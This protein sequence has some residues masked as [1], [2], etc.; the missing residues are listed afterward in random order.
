MADHP[1]VIPVSQFGDPSSTQDGLNCTSTSYV[2][3]GQLATGGRFLLPGEF[4]AL[5]SDHEGGISIPDG[6]RAWAKAYPGARLDWA[7]PNDGTPTPPNG[8]GSNIG[9]EAL[10]SL[11]SEGYGAVLQGDYD[12]F[13]KAGISLQPG[14]LDPHAIYLDGVRTI[15]RQRQGFI[16]DPLGRE[17]YN[18]RWVSWATLV[19][20]GLK[21]S[22]GH[23]LYAAWAAQGLPDTGTEDEVANVVTIERK[24]GRVS[25]PPGSAMAG[26]GLAADGTLF[27]SIP[28]KAWPNG[29][30]FRVTS[31]YT[32]TAFP[33]NNGDPITYG[34]AECPSAYCNGPSQSLVPLRGLT[35]IPD[36]LGTTEAYNAG[37]DAASAKALEARK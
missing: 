7:A 8:H 9:A 35:F 23:N 20:Y 2:M 15:I 34:L 19:A 5:Q 25:V 29:T 18:G 30:S 3:L 22:G 31:L 14:F 1:R 33:T 16:L 24:T 21:L 32:G 4:R 6:A 11:L 12:V 26:Y 17:G 27:Q 37:V 10:W 13:Q 28:V 36:A